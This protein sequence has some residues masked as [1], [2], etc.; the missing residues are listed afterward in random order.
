VQKPLQTRPWTAVA[1]DLG[2][3]STR[4]CMRAFGAS[5]EA[6]VDRYG[7]HRDVVAAERARFKE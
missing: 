6:L 5:Y 2:Y 7:S 4:E 1:D 3:V